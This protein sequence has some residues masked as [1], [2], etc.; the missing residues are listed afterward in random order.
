[1]RIIKK[2]KPCPETEIT[3]PYCES[4]LAYTVNDMQ[5]EKTSLFFRSYIQCPM[6]GRKIVLAMCVERAE[7]LALLRS[8]E[9]IP[10]RKG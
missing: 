3:C 2:G 7:Q 6:C 10:S 8:T 5:S 4:E 9:I 1:M